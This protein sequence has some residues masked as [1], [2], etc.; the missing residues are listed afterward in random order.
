MTATTSLTEA[1]AMSLRSLVDHP[2]RTT[3][4][5]ISNGPYVV[6]AF[7]PESIHDAL[8]ELELRGFAT[9]RRDRWSV[10][11]V[12]KRY[13]ASARHTRSRDA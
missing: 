13:A 8:A 5:G 11:A 1:G 12:G 4:S 10:T 2:S 6:L 3:S 9:Q 7:G